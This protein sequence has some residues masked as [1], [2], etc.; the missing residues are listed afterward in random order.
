MN[1]NN[2]KTVR[3]DLPDRTVSPAFG[4]LGFFVEGKLMIRISCVI[5]MVLSL[6][7]ARDSALGEVAGSDHGPSETETTVH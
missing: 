3:L 6:L 1:S 5:L 2:Q 7:A 4:G